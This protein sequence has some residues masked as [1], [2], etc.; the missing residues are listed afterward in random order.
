MVLLA[1]ISIIGC[2]WAVLDVTLVVPLR[3]TLY[4]MEVELGIETNKHNNLKQDLKLSKEKI[5]A[6]S[7]T[8]A[9]TKD[10]L[11]IVDKNLRNTTEN[12]MSKTV[13]LNRTI[14]QLSLKENSFSRINIK[15]DGTRNELNK[16][17]ES[18]AK[19]RNEISS[20]N[21]E[22]EKTRKNLMTSIDAFNDMQ[23]K[24]NNTMKSS[25]KYRE[26][27]EELSKIF[28]NINKDFS[29]TKRAL[30]ELLIPKNIQTIQSEILKNGN[31]GNDDLVVQGNVYD[32]GEII[33]A[34]FYLEHK[35]NFPSGKYVLRDAYK[36]A[37]MI[38]AINKFVVGIKS[39]NLEYSE[40]EL[41][42]MFEGGAD[43]FL[44]NK[45]VGIYNGEYGA[46]LKKGVLINGQI[47]DVQIY[48]GDKVTNSY[49]AFLRAFGV[50]TA[51]R[52]LAT[53]SA[54][55]LTNKGVE[56]R[57]NEFEKSGRDYRFGKISVKI[58][59]LAKNTEE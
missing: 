59:K 10:K 9:S 4:K 8:F 51:F 52:G 37:G 34:D 41:T 20:V 2:T 36:Q 30:E 27:Y 32:G 1:T 6:L 23:D 40:L 26:N 47:K 35:V 24:L 46:I 45:K 14:S 5:V 3:D 54:L 7:K 53:S 58:Y 18:L 55:V 49:L 19:K 29:D 56:F 22:L 33:T 15:L 28:E 13:E 57:A 21:D 43:T 42:G 16:T 38:D 11:T 17:L 39:M 44:Y 12:L 25:E 31:Y 48:K 50:Y